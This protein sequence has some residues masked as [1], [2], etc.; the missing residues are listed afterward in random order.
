VPGNKP[1]EAFGYTDGLEVEE[2]LL[3]I[4]R[5]ATDLSSTSSEL[6]NAIIDW[7]SRYHLSSERANLFRA[8]D[9]LQDCAQVLEL[10]AGCGALTRYLG[11][12]FE[13]VDA[14]EGSLRRAQIARERCRDLLN[15]T[16]LASPFKDIRFSPEYDLV[17]LIGVLEYA[18]TLDEPSQRN[19]AENCLSTIKS[20]ACSLRRD[21]IMIIAM[22]NAL[23]LK[24]WSGCAED[25]TGTPF[26]S[27][28]GYPVPNSPITFGRRQLESLIRLSGFD[29]IAFY[30]PFPDYKLPRTIIRETQIP[31]DSLFLHNWIECPFED[32]TGRRDYH[33][34]EGL[35]VRSICR[36]GLLSEFANSFL[37]LASK[38]PDT[39]IQASWIA[40][41]FESQRALPYQRVTSL[42]VDPNPRVRKDRVIESSEEP[43]LLGLRPAMTRWIPGD[44]EIYSLDEAIFHPDPHSSILSILERYHKYLADIFSTNTNDE[45]G[46][47]LLR[48]ESFDFT[49]SN[50]IWNSELDRYEYI[51]DEWEWRG[52]LPVDY[53][54]FRSLYYFMATRRP[55]LRAKAAETDLQQTFMSLMRALYP[56]YNFERHERNRLREERV[57][58]EIIG[59]S[60]TLASLSTPLAERTSL[61][62][63]KVENDRLRE[64]IRLRDEGIKFLQGEVK[65]R[66][67]GIKFLRESK[68]SSRIR[69]KLSWMIRKKP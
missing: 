16:V 34:H 28:H 60:F 6:E 49:F 43:S 36:A 68:L 47:P 21:G 52:P 35:A 64:V 13:K 24:Y 58:S 18:P 4:M 51:D 59:R 32:Y 41:R 53:V 10:G 9:N 40:R 30:Y 31:P 23:G 48:G 19:R 3:T 66:D 65:V 67:E 2:R 25:H 42:Y 12:R 69:R 14:I 55:Y 8:M 27:V 15:V 38:S 45:E 33:V 22:E 20:A 46:Y 5:S 63:L 54:L 44:L 62:A 26:D 1:T 39:E 50:I 29:H 57:Q 7:P 37:V 56:Q 11:E 17:A 61:L